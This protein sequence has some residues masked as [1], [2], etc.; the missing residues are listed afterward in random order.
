[1][2]PLFVDVSTCITA[3]AASGEYDHRKD[4]RYSFE[5][6][7]IHSKDSSVHKWKTPTHS[8]RG[9]AQD[10]IVFVAL[11]FFL[12]MRVMVKRSF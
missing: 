8:P 7:H 5:W 12:N 9:S 3:V 2:S 4:S 11:E 1:M 6:R 10:V